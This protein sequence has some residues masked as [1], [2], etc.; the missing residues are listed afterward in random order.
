MSRRT[1][2]PATAPAADFLETEAVTADDLDLVDGLDIGP[3]AEVIHPRDDLRKKAKARRAVPG[4]LDPVAAAEAAVA[5]MA[6]SFD[7]WMAAETTRLAT[8]FVEAEAGAFDGEALEAFHRTAHDIKGQAATLG[9]PLAGHIAAGLCRLIDAKVETGRIPRD[10][11]AQHVQ[12]VRAI[13]A[14]QARENGT[15]TARRLVERLDEV[16]SDYL[17]QIGVA[18]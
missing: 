6:D 1:P 12:S 13:I 15:A 7:G 10:L 3:D 17:A 18:A 2:T 8:L 5:R 16:T 14:E 11:V 9:F 4:E